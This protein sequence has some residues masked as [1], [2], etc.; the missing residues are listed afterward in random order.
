MGMPHL[1][2]TKANNPKQ[3]CIPN[4]NINLCWQSWTQTEHMVH[5]RVLYLMS[6]NL[7][8]STIHSGT[9]KRGTGNAWLQPP[10]NQ[11]LR[12]NTDFVISI[13]SNVLYDTTLQSKSTTTLG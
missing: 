5:D 9:P 2:I 13:I 7:Y 3:C 6:K 10:T 8:S 11:N 4:Q 1:K 12:T